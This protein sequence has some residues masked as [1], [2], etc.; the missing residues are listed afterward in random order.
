MEEDNFIPLS[1]IS[2]YNYCRRRAGLLMPEQQWNDS[3]DTVKGSPEHN[4]W[5]SK[6]DVLGVEKGFSQDQPLIL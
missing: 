1:Y 3:P 4:K 5:D 6:I 2:Q